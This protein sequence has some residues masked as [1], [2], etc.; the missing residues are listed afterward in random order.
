MTKQTSTR[1]INIYSVFISWQDKTESFCPKNKDKD[2]LE[3]E[4]TADRVEVNIFS[5]LR[6]FRVFTKVDENYKQDQIG[7]AGKS[8]VGIKVKYRWKS[9]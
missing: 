7:L 2:F 5:V 1:R 3:Q 8:S 6:I 4:E 9:V